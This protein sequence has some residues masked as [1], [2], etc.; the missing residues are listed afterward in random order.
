[1]R[2]IEEIKQRTPEEIEERKKKKDLAKKRKVL[3]RS[4]NPAVRALA[5]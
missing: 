1:M 3:L 2:E 4:G 5:N